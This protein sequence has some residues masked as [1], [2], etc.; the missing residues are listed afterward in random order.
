MM[1]VLT[2]PTKPTLVIILRHVSVCNR[3]VC[4]LKFHNVICQLN[5]NKSGK[6]KT[7]LWFLRNEFN[8]WFTL[9]PRVLHFGSTWKPGELVLLPFSACGALSLF[10]AQPRSF[11]KLFSSWVS[12]E[13]LPALA[14][15]SEGRIA[16]QTAPISLELSVLS[17]T[18]S[19]NSLALL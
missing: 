16:S 2:N 9:R 15:V 13:F 12:Q 19:S 17:G 6:K 10:V 8:F 5:L 7:V 11:P 14:Y 4:T 3:Y 1:K 18:C